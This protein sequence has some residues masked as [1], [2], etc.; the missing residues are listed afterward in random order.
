[1]K[2]FQSC[3]SRVLAFFRAHRAA[4]IVGYIL[5]AWLAFVL[6]FH[7]KGTKTYLILG[8]DNYGSL[9]VVGRSDVMM[10]VQIDFGRADISTVTFTR[11][12]LIPDENGRTQ[13]INTI[14]RQSGEDALVTAMENAFGLEIDGWFRVNFTSVIELVDAIGGV[15]LELTE[16][17]ARYINRNTGGYEPLQEGVNRLCGGQAL[18]YARCRQLDNDMMRGQRQNRLMAAMVESTRHMTIAGIV[19]V[20]DSLKHAWAS[21]LTAME[22][23]HLL[24]QALWLRGAHVTSIGMPLGGWKYSNGGVVIKMEENVQLLHEALGLPA[25]RP[26]D[27][28]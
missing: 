20:F 12:M 19:R 7:P 14:V 1:M 17:E 18:V 27:A 24:G 13:K 28:P 3:Y 9:G 8:M 2:L 23:V 15:E 10:L 16:K 22:Q 4:R 25:P 6:L 5:I 11:D 26:A 21:S